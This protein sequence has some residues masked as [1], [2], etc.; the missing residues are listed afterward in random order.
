MSRRFLQFY[1]HFRDECRR[2]LGEFEGVGSGAGGLPIQGGGGKDAP[3]PPLGGGHGGGGGGGSG[4]SSV[5]DVNSLIAGAHLQ[6][7][8]SYSNIT[9]I[10]SIK[11]F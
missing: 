4:G 3:T 8:K 6:V 9:G 1:F 5:A 7:G 10:K 11:F 2:R